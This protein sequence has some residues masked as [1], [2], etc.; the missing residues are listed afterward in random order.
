MHH[1][2]CFIWLASYHDSNVLRLNWPRGVAMD[3]VIDRNCC[4]ESW[5][6]ALSYHQSQLWSFN[7]CFEFYFVLLF[8]HPHYISRFCPSKDYRHRGGFLRVVW[9][10]FILN[11]LLASFNR[12]FD[13]TIQL[14]AADLMVVVA[15]GLV[16]CFEVLLI[17][18]YY[19]FLRK[20]LHFYYF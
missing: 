5:M 1:Q 18:V 12:H 6:R 9:V 2:Y 13:L 10:Y 14:L 7:L 17:I 3:R 16:A 11:E 4:K 15:A 19:W 8:C 20:N